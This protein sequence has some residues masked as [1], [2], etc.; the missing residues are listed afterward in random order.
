M[1]LYWRIVHRHRLWPSWGSMDGCIA[2]QSMRLPRW[3]P[4]LAAVAKRCSVGVCPIANTL[5]PSLRFTAAGCSVSSCSAVRVPHKRP[6]ADP[7]VPVA[8]QREGSTWPLSDPS[9]GLS[10]RLVAAVQSWIGTSRN[11]VSAVIEGPGPAL[12]DRRGIRDASIERSPGRLSPLHPTAGLSLLVHAFAQSTSAAINI[13][14]FR[15]P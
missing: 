8:D 13:F 4:A 15:A 14:R 6:R 5:R 1:R 11:T 9:G 2:R 12:S 7:Q 3:S 10:D